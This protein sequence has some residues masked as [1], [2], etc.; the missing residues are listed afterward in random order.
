[1][2]YR[3]EFHAGNF[4]D[5]Y[6][7]LLLVRIIEHLKNKD[8]A[9]RVIDTHAG[10]GNYPLEK[11]P[12]SDAAAGKKAEWEDGIG[13]LLNWKPAGEVGGL[14]AP[15]LEA[16]FGEAGTYVLPPHYPGSP[17]IAMRVMREK[18][19]L[20]AS[21]LYPPAFEALKSLFAGNYQAR[22]LELDGWLIPGSQIPPKEKRGV[23]MIDPPFEKPAEFNRMIE[24]LESASKRWSGGT[25]ILW[26]P[27]KHRGDVS[28]FKK[29]LVESAI[30][31]LVCYEMEIDKP[32]TVPV[33]YGCGM[34]VRHPPY[35]LGNEMTA[36]NRAILPLL[37]KSM[38]SGKATITRLTA[39]QET[40]KNP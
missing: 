16:V 3:H 7:H 26:Y 21:E 38:G 24:A 18:D 9:F 32:G 37:E 13:R 40:G 23:M 2:N 17:L 25:V 33:L 11:R 36:I 22:I 8:K 1:M 31:D 19:R 5:V 6:K 12:K 27:L 15:Y 39:E 10:S 35:R 4:A 28:L 30:S 20:S 34:I 14:V 29:L